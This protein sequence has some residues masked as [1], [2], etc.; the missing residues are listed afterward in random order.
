MA[1]I[2]GSAIIPCKDCK[3]QTKRIQKG[4]ILKVTACDPLPGQS[5]QPEDEKLC[6][7][8][9]KM[10]GLPPQPGGGG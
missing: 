2:T 1:D 7:I 10:L 9:W 4:A 3:A 5:G 8:S 6:K